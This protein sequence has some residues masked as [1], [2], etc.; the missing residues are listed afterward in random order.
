MNEPSPQM[1]IK[2]CLDPIMYTE[3]QRTAR[4]HASILD[5]HV[6]VVCTSR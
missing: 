6:P 2:V 3:R 4:L 1:Y 5:V